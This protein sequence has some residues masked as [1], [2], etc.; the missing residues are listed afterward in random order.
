MQFKRV[1]EFRRGAVLGFIIGVLPLLAAYGAEYL[2]SFS[3]CRLCLYQRLPY[4]FII[5]TSLFAGYINQNHGYK[6]YYNVVLL[7]LLVSF[8][9][10]LFHVGVENHWL[11]YKSTCTFDKSSMA[12]FEQY[13]AMINHADLSACDA[14][15][16]LFLGASMAAWN[17]LYSTVAALLVYLN[18]RKQI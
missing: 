7:G 8:C 17:A 3:P 1:L 5:A 6:V 18:F 15:T 11:Y 2:F 16:P 13:E 12:S 4:C 10:A 14:P 9:L